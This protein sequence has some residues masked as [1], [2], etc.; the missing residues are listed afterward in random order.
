MSGPMSTDW[1]DYS[2]SDY[3]I[4]DALKAGF[5]RVV[6]IV[7]TEDEPALRQRMHETVGDRCT[8]EFAC[9]CVG[10]VPD[11]SGTWFNFIPR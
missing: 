1:G 3:A 11:G 9:Q 8:V 7:R 5:S 6:L 4:Y 2:T 10:D